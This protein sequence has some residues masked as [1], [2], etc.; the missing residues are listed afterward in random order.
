M[1]RRHIITAGLVAL[2]ASP[3]LAAE[4]SKPDQDQAVKLSPVS[5]P[6]IVDHRVINYVFVETQVL[7]TPNA[8]VIALRDKEPYFRDALVRAAY[9]TPFNMQGDNNRI[10]E[11]RLKAALVREAIAIVGP[12]KIRGAQIDSQTPKRRLSRPGPSPPPV[13]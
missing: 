7:L 13:R 5:I 3:A 2:A 12:G 9:R 10:D 1:R 6:I 8:D 4:G 11:G